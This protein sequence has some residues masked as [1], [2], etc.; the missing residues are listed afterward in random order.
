MN[1]LLLVG[2]VL[3]RLRIGRTQFWQL[4]QRGDFPPPCRM[5]RP[6]RWRERDVEQWIIERA[7]VKYDRI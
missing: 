3:R 2:D 4:R 6:L 5:G 7:E 1:N